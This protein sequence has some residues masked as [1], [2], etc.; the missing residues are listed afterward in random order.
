M[1][2]D[3]DKPFG[4][5]A[6]WSPS[7]S[8]ATW[9]AA[10]KT[11]AAMQRGGVLLRTPAPPPIGAGVHLTLRFPD[12]SDVVLMGNVLDIMQEQGAV[13]R[14]RVATPILTQLESRAWGEQASVPRPSRPVARGSLP[15]EMSREM[16][17]DFTPPPAPQPPAD[18]GTTYSIHKRRK[19]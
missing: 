7:L 8:C 19:K 9:G 3:P 5:H 18:D 11:A 13:V 15:H 10:H 1:S 2:S 16:D 14:F 12:G 17:S 4:D 6:A